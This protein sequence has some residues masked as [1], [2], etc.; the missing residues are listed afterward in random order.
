[1]GT[2][3]DPWVILGI[4]PG[5]DFK[6]VRR[7]YAAK[8]KGTHPEDDPAGF[9]RLREAYELL[10]QSLDR[11]EPVEPAWMPPSEAAAPKPEP[12]PVPKRRVRERVAPLTPGWEV[13]EMTGRFMDRARAI[14]RDVKLCRSLSAWR[15]LLKDDALSRVDVRLELEKALFE[16]LAARKKGLIWPVWCLLEKE[17][18]WRDRGFYVPID[19]ELD[20]IHPIS[21]PPARI[22]NVARERALS[23]R[24]SHTS[25]TLT[26]SWDPSLDDRIPLVCIHHFGWFA[27][28][29]TALV[30]GFG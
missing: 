8:L 12:A 30:H 26:E 5:S 3:T 17:F 27:V 7:A 13:A 16:F 4:E 1:M 19:F 11:R 15:S 28:A 24:T 23:Q 2:T 6:L 22:S 9:L 10:R 29:V 14:C 21:A 18:L 25:F 20:S